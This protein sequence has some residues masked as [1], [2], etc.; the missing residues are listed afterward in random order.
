MS[1]ALLYCAVIVCLLAILFSGGYLSFRGQQVAKAEAL[2]AQYNGRSKADEDGVV[3]SLTLRGREFSQDDIGSLNEFPSL[4]SLDLASTGITDDSLDKLVELKNLESLSLDNTKVTDR[5][6]AK[7]ESLQLKQ[8]SLT[9]TCPGQLTVSGIGRLQSLTSLNVTGCELTDDSAEAIGALS[10]LKRLYLGRTQMTAA[11]LPALCNLKNLELLN[12]AELSLNTPQDITSIG[13]MA[14]LE[15]LYLDNADFDDQAIEQLA[16]SCDRK[17]VT[18]HSVFLEGCNI[19]DAS[20]RAL[21]L[22]LTQPG[23]MKLRLT[24]TKVSR[25]VFDEL[26]K[27]SPEVSFSHG[28]GS[29]GE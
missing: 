6:L 28:T 5:G 16:K 7:L 24:G 18:L 23:F 26:R 20:D 27:V 17:S 10:N 19:T 3:T 25:R 2:S 8:L 21:R 22:L 9:G 11:C 12:L 15:L 4:K 13:D 29:E 14:S 1:K